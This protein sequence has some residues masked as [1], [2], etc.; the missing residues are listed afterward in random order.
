[1]IVTEITSKEEEGGNPPQKLLIVMASVLS[2]THDCNVQMHTNFNHSFAE[3]RQI[4]A[5]KINSNVE[6]DCNK[7]HVLEWNFPGQVRLV[8]GQG[9]LNIYMLV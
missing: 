8:S 6:S 1:M 5:N 4:R 9:N 2:I 3:N 7:Q